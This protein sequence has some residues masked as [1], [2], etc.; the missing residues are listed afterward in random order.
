M[1]MS[2][3]TVLP[4][5]R[6]PEFRDSGEWSYNEIGSIGVVVTGKTPDTED[7]SLWNGDIQFVTPTDISESKYQYVTQRSVVNKTNI[8]VLPKNSILFTC[9]A[10]VGKMAITVHPCITNQQINALIP[11]NSYSNEYIYYALL[12]KSNVIKSKLANTT[13]PIINKT[14]FSKFTLGIP[15][16]HKEQQKIVDCLSSLDDLITAEDKKLALLKTHKKGLMQKLFP[17]E[18]ETVPQVRFKGYTDDWELRRLDDVAEFNPK[19][20][21]PDVFEYVDLESVV[22]TEMISHRTENRENAPSRAQRLAQTGDVFFQTVRPYQQNNHYF[23]LPYDN[24]VFS[25]GYAQLRPHVDGY[26]LLSRLQE[27][28]FVENVL[29]KSTGTSYPAISSSD[30]AKIAISIPVDEREQTAIGN[31]FRNLDEIITI[32]TEKIE[33]I[34]LH[35]KGLMQGLFPSVQEV[36][37]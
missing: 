11:H 31:F 14:E 3:K 37:R 13:L 15:K 30:L 16:D 28:K 8:K 4:K 9:I 22:G 32:Q 20:I 21:L 5:L 17:A 1:R 23:N 7:E 33:V 6:F 26:F 2:K 34:K 27:K 24:F 10:S 29:D 35:K 12:K 25:T 18:G 19:S 36:F